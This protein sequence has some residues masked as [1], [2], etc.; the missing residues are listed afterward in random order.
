M[1]EISN[2]DE[3]KNYFKKLQRTINIDADFKFID[4]Y[5]VKKNKQT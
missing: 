2:V 1:T 5:L 4:V 3:L